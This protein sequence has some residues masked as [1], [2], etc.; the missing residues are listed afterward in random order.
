MNY[1]KMREELKDFY[2]E[3]DDIRAKGLADKKIAILD[4]KKTDDMSPEALKVLQYGVI[5]EE[6]EPVIFKNCP[7]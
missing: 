5:A 6:C 7:Y 3:G 2:W 1:T 4:S